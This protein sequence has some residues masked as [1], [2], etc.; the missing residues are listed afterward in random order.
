M[1]EKKNVAKD[2]PDIVSALKK[3]LNHIKEDLGFQETIGKNSRR[4]L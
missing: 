4:T 3:H 1:G 2:N